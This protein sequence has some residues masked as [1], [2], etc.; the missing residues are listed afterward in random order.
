MSKDSM[1]LPAGP[2][3]CQSDQQAAPYL[4]NI[5]NDEF[6]RLDILFGKQA[7]SVHP[8]SPEPQ[9]LGP[10]LHANTQVALRI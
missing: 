8:T 7:P 3:S 1:A 6:F 4:T 5:L 10:P 2:K 9:V